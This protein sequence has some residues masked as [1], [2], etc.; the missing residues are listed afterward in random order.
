MAR[1]KDWS[2]T[3]KKVRSVNRTLHPVNPMQLKD[4]LRQPSKAELRAEAE[5][6]VAAYRKRAM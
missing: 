5:R 2:K 4:S 6:A 3:A 1:N